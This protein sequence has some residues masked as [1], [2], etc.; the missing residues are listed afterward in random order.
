MLA[1]LA[2]KVLFIRVLEEMYRNY[3]SNITRDAQIQLFFLHP[4]PIL[5]TSISTV[6]RLQ[7]GFYITLFVSV[8]L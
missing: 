1:P 5:R 8:L 4:I 2:V 6:K 7:K 3:W